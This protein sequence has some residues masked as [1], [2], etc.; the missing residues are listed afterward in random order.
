MSGLS[1]L[2]DRRAMARN[3]ARPD[4]LASGNFGDVATVGGGVFEL[5]VNY[6]PGYRVYIACAEASIA[7]FCFVAETSHRRTGTS[8]RPG[9]LPESGRIEPCKK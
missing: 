7:L 6:G 1:G 5:R 4:R 3:A 9:R 2:R 8:S